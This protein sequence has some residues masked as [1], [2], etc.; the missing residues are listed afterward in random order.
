MRPTPTV[1]PVH[2]MMVKRKGSKIKKSRKFSHCQVQQL[3]AYFKKKS[4]ITMEER[5]QFAATLGI[6][7][8]QVRTWF[9]NRRAMHKKVSCLEKNSDSTCTPDTIRPVSTLSITDSVE[10]S[11]LSS[12]SSTTSVSPP[13]AYD[14]TLYYHGQLY[15]QQQPSSLPPPHYQ[16]QQ[17]YGY[18]YQKPSYQMAKNQ[19]YQQHMWHQPVWS[20][21][22][23]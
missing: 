18:E 6:T 3:Q 16:S 2:T 1:K 8:L 20:N 23:F 11:S 19:Q 10:T 21:Q 9:Q 5:K 22:H 15:K 17:I 12:A 13:A 14:T 7:E 4:Y